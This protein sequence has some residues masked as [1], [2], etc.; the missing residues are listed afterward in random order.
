MRHTTSRVGRSRALPPVSLLGTLV[1]LVLVLV[2]LLAPPPPTAY[3]AAGSA[4]SSSAT[5]KGNVTLSRASVRAGE[6]ATLRGSTS[7]GGRLV[8]LQRLDAAGRWRSLGSVKAAA[9]GAFVLKAPTW[10]YGTHT[11][12]A[13]APASGRAP[14]WVS[15]SVRNVVTPT[16]P[17]AGRATSYSLDPGRWNPC[18]TI[19]YRINTAGSYRGWDKQVHAVMAEMN[20]ATGIRFEYR[21]TTGEVAF[22][23]TRREGSD[24]VLSWTTPGQDARVAGAV[25]GVGGSYYQRVGT[26]DERFRGSIVLD[27]TASLDT[28]WDGTR[29]T[30]WASVMLHELA[31][32]MGIGHTSDS[33]QLLYSAAPLKPRFGRGDLAGLALRGAGQPCIAG[34]V[35]G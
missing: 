27:R 8:Q 34:S 10:W 18:R 22:G 29:T 31:H 21:G 15:A 16:Y 6:Q 35:R 19:G 12:R 11:L 7:L 26:V 25:V 4:T 5:I 3:A 14:G 13:W 24:I 28:T 1:V 33:T 23:A 32:V 20:R 9:N 17:T 2:L 30:S